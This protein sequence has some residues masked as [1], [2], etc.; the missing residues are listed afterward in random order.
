MALEATTRPNDRGL[1]LTAAQEIIRLLEEIR[2]IAE[3]PEQIWVIEGYC[4][5]D[6]HEEERAK[7]Q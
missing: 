5:L 1:A 6:K 4:T 2:R 3:P 7:V